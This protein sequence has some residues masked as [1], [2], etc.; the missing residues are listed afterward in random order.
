MSLR[1]YNLTT[2]ESTPEVITT[3]KAVHLKEA[4]Y[5]FSQ[6]KRLTEEEL[7]ELFYV[8]RGDNQDF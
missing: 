3:T 2:K 5:L 4:T 8:V 7:L 1:T 6:I